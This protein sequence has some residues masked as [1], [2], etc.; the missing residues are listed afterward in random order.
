MKNNIKD[1][2]PKTGFGYFASI[3]NANAAI[4]LK[5]NKVNSIATPQIEDK[6]NVGGI[7]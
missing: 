6:K 7:K 3:M 2:D 1:Y 4:D 5:Q